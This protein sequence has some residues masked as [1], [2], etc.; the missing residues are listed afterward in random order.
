MILL[1]AEENISCPSKC[2]PDGEAALM[3]LIQFVLVGTIVQG[4]GLGI[5]IWISRTGLSSVGKPAVICV[6]SGVMALLLWH[7]IKE[8]CR[9]TSFVVVP[10]VFSLCYL[11]AFHIIGLFF[12]HWLLRD[13]EQSFGYMFSLL[14]TAVVIFSLYSGG[15]MF[16]HYLTRLT[17]ARW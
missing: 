3:R 4:L 9:I 15:A 5:F 2:A 13:F 10:V 11:A 14:R 12:F 16:F 17:A 1:S 7:A 8:G 6:T